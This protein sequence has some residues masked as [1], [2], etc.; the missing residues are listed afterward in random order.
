MLKLA[1]NPETERVIEKYGIGFDVIYFAG[2]E[3]GFA[4]GYSE[5]Y[6]EGFAEGRFEVV[7]NFIAKGV[8]L[9]IISECMDISVKELEEIKRKL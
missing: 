3:D 5:G 1:R 9:N 4:E 7:G 6:S 8:D 2:K